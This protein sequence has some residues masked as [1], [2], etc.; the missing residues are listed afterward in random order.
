MKPVQVM[1]V[2]IIVVIVLGLASREMWTMIPNTLGGT[3][4]YPCTG[5]PEVTNKD[6]CQV[7]TGVEAKKKCNSLPDCAGYSYFKGKPR[8]WGGGTT[9][10]QL[11]GKAQ[12]SMSPNKEWDF[13]KK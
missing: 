10:T 13:Y 9:R 4:P 5:G 3:A 11:I 6:W 1:I 2:I 8:K 12:L 7:T